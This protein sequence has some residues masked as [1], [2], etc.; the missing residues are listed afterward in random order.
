[1]SAPIF[2]S[3]DVEKNKVRGGLGYLIPFAPYFLCR[4][5]AFGRY[6]AN[7]GLIMW[8]CIAIVS[9]AFGI[10]GGVIGWIPLLGPLVRWILSR[11]SGVVRMIVT[12]IM[13]YYAVMAMK[14]GRANEVPVVGGIKLLK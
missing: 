11:A 4:E 2:G 12:V 1:M 13:I 14:F 5:S 9:V 3:D 7:Q 8:I 10:I 6:C